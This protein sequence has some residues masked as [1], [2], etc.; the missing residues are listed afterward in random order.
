MANPEFYSRIIH[1]HDIET[2]W[3]TAANNSNFIPKQGEI[4]V[5]DKDSNYNYERIKIGDGVTNVAN[6][7]FILDSIDTDGD[8]IV[9]NAEKVNGHTVLSNVPANAIFTDEKVKQQAMTGTLKLPLLLSQSATGSTMTGVAY[10]DND[11]KLDMSTNTISANIS[12]NAATADKATKDAN[13]NNIAS[14]YAT[15]S[16]SLP[17]LGMNPL[18]T[19]HGFEDVQD[20]VEK[21]GEVGSGIGS[22]GLAD[23][24]VMYE[25]YPSQYNAGLINHVTKNTVT[26]QIEAVY[27]IIF[28]FTEKGTIYHR[29]GGVNGW[30]N[31]GNW[32]KVFD[33]GD[34]IPIANGGTGATTAQGILT[35]LGITA[36]VAELNKLDGVT[37]TTTELNYVDGVTS[38][39]QTQ[40]NNKIPRLGV[41]PLTTIVGAN[42]TDTVADWATIGTGVGVIGEDDRSKIT[43]Y[44]NG[45]SAWIFNLRY[46]TNTSENTAAI[47]Q[48]LMPYGNKSTIYHRAG[49]SDTGWYNDSQWAMIYDSNTV[50][51]IA[52]GGTGAT[53]ASAALANLNGV[54]IVDATGSTNDMDVIFKSGKQVKVY[55]TDGN[56]LNTP[57][58]A[59]KTGTFTGANIFTITESATYGTQI[60]FINGGNNQYMRKLSNNTIG[61]WVKIIT[62]T[63]LSSCATAEQGTNSDN[64][65]ANTSNPHSVTKSQVGLGNVTNNKQMPIAGG[66]FIGN[67]IAYSTNRT[68][69]CLRNISVVNSAG[70][71]NQSTNRI[72]MYRK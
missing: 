47:Y 65:I 10:F 9:D 52:N 34:I 23:R 68:S 38:N 3:N 66:T 62:E 16:K 49:N 1:K 12:G 71:T 32:I 51:P 26:G 48:L 13:G 50:V 4:I 72:I 25:T 58:K 67:A 53:T 42:A 46:V 15:I 19:T 64:H 55:R 2:N 7:P 14:T 22:I 24:E 69:S 21:W 61:E 17:K 29:G 33:N 44:P 5:Y 37:A 8:G 56:T 60:A 6:L 30:Y 18:T 28:P 36:T 35:N 54:E 27:Q 20:S 59:G 43:N 11:V 63:D 57:Y 40:L 41:N 45:Y 39:I 31:N 70:T